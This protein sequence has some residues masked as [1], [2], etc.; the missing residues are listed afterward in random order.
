M[1]DI[2]FT[3]TNGGL[4]RTAASEDPISGLVLFNLTG[5][6]ESSTPFVFGTE[7]GQIKGFEAVT[8]GNETAYVKKF[9][10]AEQ[11]EE[12]GIEYE[13]YE[14]TALSELQKAKNFVH[15]HISEFFRMNAGGTVYLMLANS[16]VSVDA[17]AVLQNYANGRLRQI[18]VMTNGDNATAYQLALT[19]M[20]ANHKPASLVL[21]KS[22]KNAFA[23]RCYTHR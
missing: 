17:I 19:E 1:N 4:A 15:Y 12:C 2:K 16:D 10:F 8:V 13:K 22:G 14:D 21:T 3:K 20:E 11:L 9:T 18:G 5:T 7:D 23:L 6:G